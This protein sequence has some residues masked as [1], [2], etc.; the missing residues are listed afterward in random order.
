MAGPQMS[1]TRL[2]SLDPYNESAPWN[3]WFENVCGASTNCTAENPSD[4][5][6]AGYGVIASFI[7]TAVLTV[8]TVMFAYITKSLPESRYNAVDDQFLKGIYWLFRIKEY[9]PP[10]QPSSSKM[11]AANRQTRIDGVERF[12]LVLSDQQ[13]VT[14]IAVLVASYARFCTISHFS[15]DVALNL[16]WLSCTAHLATLTVLQAYFDKHKAV[17]NWRVGAMIVLFALLVPALTTS[18]N[19]TTAKQYLFACA[20]KKLAVLANPVLMLLLYWLASGYGSRLLEIYCPRARR[21]RGHWIAWAILR[22]WL[23]E[24][25]NFSKVYHDFQ[26]DSNGSFLCQIIWLCFFLTYGI[27]QQVV[28]YHWTWIPTQPLKQMGFGQIVPLLLITL[29]LLSAGESYYEWRDTSQ[30]MGE[31]GGELQVISHCEVE[32]NEMAEADGVFSQ[33]GESEDEAE[34]VDAAIMQRT[35]TGN[36]ENGVP[37]SVSTIPKPAISSWVWLLCLFSYLEISGFF[38]PTMMLNSGPVLLLGIIFYIGLVCFLYPVL[39][40]IAAVGLVLH[41]KW[42][43]IGLA[44]P[45]RYRFFFRN[46]HEW[47]RTY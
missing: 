7:V 37:L 5:D 40:V 19:A 1:P 47:L 22:C 26:N 41:A 35:T 17:R 4:P 2:D 9:R 42:P 43:K 10:S 38:L 46:A 27:S 28:F 13:L 45:Y 29:P 36:L 6:I 31:A 14:G 3:H 12:M 15:F 11:E 23:G 21:F 30:L 24:P 8:I 16:S 20:V 33:D 39:Q 18:F 32:I 34:P 44:N 25:K